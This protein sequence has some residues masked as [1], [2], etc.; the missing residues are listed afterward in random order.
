MQINGIILFKQI[1]LYTC[2][3]ICT[4]KTIFYAPVRVIEG[5][6]LYILIVVPQKFSKSELFLQLSDIRM[7]LFIF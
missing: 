6:R 2:D 1:S 7:Y 5:P 4:Y 3:I